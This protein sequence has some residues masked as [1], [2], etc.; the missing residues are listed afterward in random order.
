MSAQILELLFFAGIAFLIINKLISTLGMTNH[1][2]VTKQ[3]FF[4]EKN[5]NIK[6]VTPTFSPSK[7]KD[8]VFHE[9]QSNPN[10]AATD[11][12]SDI[13]IG[14]NNTEIIDYITQIQQSV[15]S[16]NPRKF[17]ENSKSAFKMIIEAANS[18]GE[19]LKMLI[20]KRFMDQFEVISSSYGNIQNIAGLD[21][22]V[23]DIH[24][25]GNN[26]LIK[27]LF[28]GRNIVSN[29]ENFAEEWTFSRNLTQNSPNWYLTSID[30]PH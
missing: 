1:D 30:R 25:F 5:N 26:F 27:I 10:N 28:S 24:K 8:A 23:S 9:K 4:G 14:D 11:N 15:R 29:I 7:F 18:N 2:D 6:D 17:L 21:A 16:F 12:Y 3:S 20:D 13:I 22:K 19:D